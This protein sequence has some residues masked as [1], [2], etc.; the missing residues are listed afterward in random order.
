MGSRACPRGLICLS[1]GIF[2]MFMFPE[3]LG[4]YVHTLVGQ[5]AGDPLPLYPYEVD[6]VGCGMKCNS[7]LSVGLAFH[8]MLPVWSHDECLAVR[9]V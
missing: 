4:R 1:V 2:A 7:M 3:E 6:G 5:V 8:F 9:A